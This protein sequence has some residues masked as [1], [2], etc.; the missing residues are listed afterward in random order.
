M[1]RSAFI[2]R[3]Q[4]INILLIL[5]VL[6]LIYDGAAQ[7]CT[8]PVFPINY[9]TWIAMKDMVNAGVDPWKTTFAR[10]QENKYASYNYKVMGDSSRT[11]L[12]TTTGDYNKLKFDGLAAYYKL[13]DVVHYR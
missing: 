9:L 12:I 8:P 4:R 1:K 11:E 6:P 2:Y 13:P 10:L 7:V 5:A 3:C